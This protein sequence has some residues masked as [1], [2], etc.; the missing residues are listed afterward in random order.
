M[1]KDS[2]STAPAL[3]PGRCQEIIPAINKIS[4]SLLDLTLELRTFGTNTL[5]N[6]QKPSPQT[7]IICHYVQGDSKNGPIELL[8]Q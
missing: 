1:V 7:F 4:L 3:P 6:L 8:E 5:C 2:G